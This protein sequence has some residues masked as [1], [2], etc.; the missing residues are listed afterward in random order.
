MTAADQLRELLATRPSMPN[1]EELMRWWRISSDLLPEILESL[2]RHER[3]AML[4][5]QAYER[6]SAE[7]AQMQQR[8]DT[9]VDAHIET[10][11][12]HNEERDRLLG[13]L[14]R[15]Q[16]ARAQLRLE[17]NNAIRERD[18]ARNDLQTR[19]RVEGGGR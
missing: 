6:A 2:Q 14:R 13:A 12:A 3:E 11:R 10:T 9:A 15:E 16:D 7:R 4:N 8:L 17:L 18:T 1:P 19:D 5:L